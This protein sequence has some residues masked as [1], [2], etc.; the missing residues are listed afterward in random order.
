MAKAIREACRWGHKNWF[1]NQLLSRRFI[2]RE[3]THEETLEH[4][5]VEGADYSYSD[6]V[7]TVKSA[8]S[9]TIKNTNPDTATFDRIFVQEGVS[10]NITLAGVNI[11]APSTNA[12]FQIENNGTGNVTITLASGSKNTLQGGDYGTGSG[13]GAGRRFE[14]VDNIAILDGDI[15]AV[16]TGNG[17][18]MPRGHW[19]RLCGRLV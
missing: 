9:L 16:G 19:R 14:E 13:I 10:A 18:G 5:G 11:S 1:A 8:T 12:A 3:D 15:T 4:G 6:G 17:A 2:R 7:L